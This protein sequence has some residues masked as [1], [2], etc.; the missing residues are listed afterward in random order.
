[1]E[2]IKNHY[3]KEDIQR[4]PLNNNSEQENV[5]LKHQLE[6]EK[7]KDFHLQQQVDHHK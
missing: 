7:L 3:L 4:T 1:M 2:H 6:M 5:Q